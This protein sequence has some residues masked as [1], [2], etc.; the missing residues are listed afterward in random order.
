MAI[1]ESLKAAISIIGKTF[2][3]RMQNKWVNFL[4]KYRHNKSGLN[5]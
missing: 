3:S 4:E 1:K 5:D 2:G